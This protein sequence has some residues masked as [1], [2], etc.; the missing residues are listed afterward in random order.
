VRITFDDDYIRD[1]IDIQAVL[2]IQNVLET[3]EIQF[4][5]IIIEQSED[6]E[7]TFP[8]NPELEDIY[9]KLNRKTET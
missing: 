9:R 7:N 5:R 6:E 4:D 3:L 2:I 8:E 1:V